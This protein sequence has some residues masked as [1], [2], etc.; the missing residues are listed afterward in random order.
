MDAQTDTLLGLLTNNLDQI[1]PR[2]TLRTLWNLIWEKHFWSIEKLRFP[3]PPD[4]PSHSGREHNLEA[5]YKHM[6]ESSDSGTRPKM[7]AD[8]H[9]DWAK[10][11]ENVFQRMG[12]REQTG[13]CVVTTRTPLACSSVN[14]SV[15]LSLCHMYE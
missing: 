1:G 7:I 9:A 13:F 14:G 8:H 2:V 11:Q 15:N 10:K 6:Q 5:M 4:P 3:V 12:C